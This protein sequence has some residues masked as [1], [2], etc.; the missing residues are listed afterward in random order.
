[1]PY[2]KDYKWSLKD[3]RLEILADSGIYLE[4]P[5]YATCCVFMDDCYIWL[6]L[7]KDRKKYKIT[8]T[9]KSP[10]KKRSDFAILAQEFQNEL[11]SNLLRYKIA[12]RNQKVREWVVK[13]ALFFSQP[14]KEQEKA[15]WRLTGLKKSEKNR[16]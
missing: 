5:V 14:K 9:P 11:L 6:D 13:E 16:D 12:R 1:M 8:L 10:L 2:S 7:S 4:E 15:A 3:N